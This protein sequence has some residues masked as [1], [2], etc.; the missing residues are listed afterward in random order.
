MAIISF[1]RILGMAGVMLFALTLASGGALAGTVY[2]NCDCTPNTNSGCPFTYCTCV[3]SQGLG[4]L[5][6]N[7]YRRNCTNAKYPV[8]THEWCSGSFPSYMV[9]S[10]PKNVTCTAPLLG[11][12]GSNYY[13]DDCTNWNLS[14]KHFNV[15]TYCSDVDYQ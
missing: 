2:T 14:S 11:P 10:L 1:D 4:A 6:T 7:E 8:N 12:P 3:S 5:D 9:G 13:Y 15:Y